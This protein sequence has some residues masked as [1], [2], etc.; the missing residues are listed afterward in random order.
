MRI[1]M[2]ISLNTHVDISSI[3]IFST[4]SWNYNS[5]V[6]SW[7]QKIANDNLFFTN[8]MIGKRYILNKV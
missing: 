2:S 7:K 3:D 1:R 8:N 6:F 4:T 5:Q